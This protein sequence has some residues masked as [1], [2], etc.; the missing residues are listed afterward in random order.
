MTSSANVIQLRPMPQVEGL[1]VTEG[2]QADWDAAGA[3]D[4]LDRV[5]EFGE[6]VVSLRAEPLECWRLL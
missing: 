6:K 1:V 3:K 2:T 4:P 5:N